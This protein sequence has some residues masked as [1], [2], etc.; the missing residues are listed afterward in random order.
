MNGEE[1][2]TIF[3]PRNFGCGVV[4]RN[5]PGFPEPTIFTS[6]GGNKKSRP[7]KPKKTLR[8]KDVKK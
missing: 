4:G 2:G 1:D 7:K 6:F 3:D 8:N 5:L